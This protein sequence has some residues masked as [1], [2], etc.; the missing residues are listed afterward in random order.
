MNFKG[1]NNED[2]IKGLKLDKEVVKSVDILNSMKGIKTTASCSGHGHSDCY[3]DFVCSNWVSLKKIVKA[4]YRIRWICGDDFDL[5]VHLW[6]VNFVVAQNYKN[7]LF[8][9]IGWQE[10]SIFTKHGNFKRINKLQAWAVLEKSLEEK[11]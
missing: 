7:G 3:I 8:C 2:E 11:Q 4:V 1:K 5:K 10:D 6:I 9:S